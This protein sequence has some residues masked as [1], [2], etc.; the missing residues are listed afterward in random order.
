MTTVSA[1]STPSISVGSDGKVTATNLVQNLDTTS[2]IN[3][4]MT[5]AGV[6]QVQL[7]A[8]MKTEQT[9]LTNYQS[10][11]TALQS[12]QTSVTGDL[13]ANAMNLL[14]ATSSYSS[15]KATATTNATATQLSLQVTQVAA[16][17]VSVTASTGAFTGTAFTV[18]GAD[19]TQTE[20]NAASTNPTDVATAINA[21]KVGIAATAVATGTDAN[22]KTTYRLQLTSAQSGSSAS[23][24][25]Y[26]GTPSD[27]T[28]GTATNLLTATGAA[29]ISSAQDAEVTLWPGTAA[30]Q[31]VTSSTNV[32]SDIEPGLSVTVSAPTTATATI[33][34]SRDD[35]SISTM[36]GNVVSGVNQLLSY[37]STQQAGTTT[38]AADGTTTFT[39]GS[40]TGDSMTSELYTQ[41][42]Q[43]IAQP[44]NGR[45]P[46]AYGIAINSDGTLSFDS[47]KFTTALDSDPE[48]TT[49]AIQ[50]IFGRVNTAVT[51]AS[52][53]YKGY[54]TNSISSQQSS[55]KA[56]QATDTNWTT[57]LAAQKTMLTAKYTALATT[58]SQMQ[59]ESSYLTQQVD[60]WSSNNN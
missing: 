24:S 28:A 40:F 12:L 13:S 41:L 29:T 4:L 32:F 54:I 56:D 22:G 11:N 20:V 30:A 18:V 59:S 49:A 33:T 9:N 47:S 34:T 57:R 31:T 7:E 3:A 53:P 46:S 26:E 39:A 21:A 27:V 45:S 8:R 14:T 48:G 60:Q 1:T 2:I 15:I 42:Q 10:L 44:V 38:T 17:Q 36:A 35:S 19:G 6:Q 43:A 37:I 58:L 23:F 16:K 52:D 5:A 50:I 25:F 55:I 51:A